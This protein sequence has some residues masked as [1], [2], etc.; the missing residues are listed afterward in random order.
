MQVTYVSIEKLPCRADDSLVALLLR[1]DALP[2]LMI[3]VAILSLNT[4]EVIRNKK[5]TK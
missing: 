5:Q 2:Y 3:F 4:V 1:D